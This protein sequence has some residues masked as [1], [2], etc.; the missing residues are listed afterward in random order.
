MRLKMTNN[1]REQAIQKLAKII[2]AKASYDEHY[3]VIDNCKAIAKAM[4]DALNVEIVSKESEPQEGDIG[5]DE[6]LPVAKFNGSEW[7]AVN[8]YGSFT[9]TEIIRRNNRVVQYMENIGVKL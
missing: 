6:F 4:L 3:S 9:G 5:R 2:E 1:P 8:E 7:V